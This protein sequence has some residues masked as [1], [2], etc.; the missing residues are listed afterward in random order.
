MERTDL[1][2]EDAERRREAAAAE[3]D[4]ERLRALASETPVAGMALLR[5][6]QALEQAERRLS[7]LRPDAVD[8]S[9][10]A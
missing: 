10:I 9:P 2:C 6:Q 4:D 7:E 3:V 5:A 8:S 1:E